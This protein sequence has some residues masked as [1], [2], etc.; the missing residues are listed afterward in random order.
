MQSF[1]EFHSQSQSSIDLSIMEFMSFMEYMEQLEEGE[2]NGTPLSESY[3]DGL[4]ME[5]NKFKKALEKIGLEV[6][7]NPRGGLIQMFTKI[8]KTVGKIIY[9]ATRVSFGDEGRK[10]EL[11]KLLKQTKREDIIDFLLKLDLATA[12][13]VTAPLHMI[14]ALTGWELKAVIHKITKSADVIQVKVKHA[15]EDIRGAVKN[16]STAIFDKKSKK[17]LTHTIDQLWNFFKDKAPSPAS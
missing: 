9:L 14:D 3:E 11:I 16:M 7:Y 6:E 2:L 12:H 17:R 1:E 8:G 5:A 13:V 15:I 4:L 10:P